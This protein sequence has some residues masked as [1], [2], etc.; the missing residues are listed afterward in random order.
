VATSEN[1]QIFRV[2]GLMDGWAK[3]IHQIAVDKGF[4]PNGDRNF[5]EVLALMH[6]ELSEALEEHR[7]GK[8][9]LYFIE[10]ID[11]QG[12]TGLKPEGVA[13]ELID[14]VIRIFDTLATLDLGGRTID[15]ILAMKVAYNS[16]RPHLHGARY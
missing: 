10:T 8:P 14:C 7:K 5:G 15:G 16:T 4:Y 13:V 2:E 12:N 3:K 11:A 6:S 1:Q 9:N